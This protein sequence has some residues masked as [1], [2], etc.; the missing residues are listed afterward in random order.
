MYYMVRFWVA[1][2]THKA[3]LSAIVEASYAALLWHHATFSWT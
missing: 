1:T 2:M 3:L